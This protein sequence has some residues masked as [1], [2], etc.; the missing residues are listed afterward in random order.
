MD[1][2]GLYFHYGK[3]CCECAEFYCLNGT[4]ILEKILLRSEG[5]LQ[6]QACQFYQVGSQS[7]FSLCRGLDTGNP[8]GS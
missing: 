8:D 2:L 7:T 3:R 1:G 5:L 4:S 6:H